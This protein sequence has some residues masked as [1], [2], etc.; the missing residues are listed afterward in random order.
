[1]PTLRK[2]IELPVPAAEA[3][4]W[5]ERPGALERLTPP[6]AA[7]TVEQPPANLQVGTRVI[8]RTGIGP[9]RPRWVAEHVVYDPPHEFRDVQRSGPFAQWDHRHR[10]EDLPSGGCAL[11]DEVTYRLPFGALGATLGRWFVHRQISRMFDYRHQRTLADLTAHAA[12]AAT[13]HQETTMKVAITGASGMIGRAISAFLT[14]GGH[15]VFA[16]VRRPATTP[17]E[18]RWD[19]SAGTVDTDRLRGIDAVI[20]L[21]ADPISARPLTPAKRRSL[22]DSRVQGTRTIATAL[23]QMPDGPKV[24]LSASGSNIYG[25]R[26]DEILTETSV[27]GVGGLL[28]DIARDWEAAT[29]PAADAGIRVVLVRTGIVL[30]RSATVLKAL[31]TV[32]RLG[33]AAPLGTGQQYWPW[34]SIDD[35]VGLYHHALITPEIEGPFIASG[36][37]PVT[38]EEFT[39]TLAR[40]LHRPVLPLRVPRV[41]PALLLGKDLA[42]SLLFTSMRMVPA[43]AQET[44]YSFAHTTLEAALRDL[45]GR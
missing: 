5:H 25:D 20:H 1:M 15:E 27:P 35:V 34:V 38:N 30:D 6:W 10:F 33:G 22:Y 41:A 2:R 16:L 32:T 26:G 8:L 12:T 9:I 11:T 14:T 42:D 7:M 17:H 23:A 21:A 19:P 45:Y 3:F 36:P 39:R 18:I 31:G 4:A 37:A 24:L 44:G 40:V 13:R 43:R 29:R 28:C